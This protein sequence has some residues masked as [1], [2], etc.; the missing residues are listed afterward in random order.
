LK[1][2][3]NWVMKVYIRNSGFSARASAAAHAVGLPVTEHL[4]TAGNAYEGIEGHEHS[5]AGVGYEWTTPWRADLIQIAKAADMCVTPTLALYLR[6]LR[7]P[8]S[9]IEVDITDFTESPFLPPFA[10]QLVAEEWSPPVNAQRRAD[11]ERYFRESM[12]SML[13]LH[14]AGVRV[15]TGT[16][17]WPEGNSLQWELELLVMAGF[18]PL[19]AIRAATLDAASCLGVDEALGS[20]TPGK[21][22]DLVLVTGDPATRIQ[23]AA[24]VEMVFLGGRP[25]TR[26]EILRLVQQ[27]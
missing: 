5:N 10:R 21:F 14:R 2:P 26:S 22:A 11:Y 15:V 4:T 13:A 8:G 18:T 7:G 17:M 3:K 19:E 12:A 9:P 1:A 25:V 27:R 20:V 23:D 24:N 6:Q 16:D